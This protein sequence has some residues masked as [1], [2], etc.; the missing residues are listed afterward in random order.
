MI[1]TY[2]TFCFLFIYTISLSQGKID[3]FYKGQGNGSAVIGFGFED[4]K[5]YFAGT[6]KIDL[7]RS[8]YYINAFA[9]Y[10]IT[11]NFD[12]SLSLPFIISNE[13]KDLQ[14]ITL[15][16]KYRF[17]TTPI[18]N[19][20]FEVSAAGGFSTPVSNYDIGGLNDIGQQATTIDTRG[21]L[22]YK[23]N[24]GWFATL[25]SGYIFKFE[26]VPNSIPI[27]FKLGKAVSKWYYDVYYDYQHSFG[28]IDYLGTPRPQNFREFGVDYHK[29]GGS[30]YTSF[31]KNFGGY[32]SLSYVISGRNVFQGPSYGV[33]IVYN[34]MKN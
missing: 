10:G 19:G 2:L 5:K 3:G 18:G 22:H 25:Q 8:L 28:G 24:S 15:F 4:T 29:V 30:L 26:E 14:D 11:D 9:N 16:L 6:E 31:S 27:V 17:Y 32:A 21:V 34:F 33:G 20:I 1:K 12:A 23:F 7:S 13:N